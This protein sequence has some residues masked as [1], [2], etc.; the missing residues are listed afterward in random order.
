[1]CIEDVNVQSLN[2]N[3]TYDQHSL[4]DN[5]EYFGQIKY[6]EEKINDIKKENKYYENK[7]ILS[8]YFEK[9][10]LYEFLR[11]IV[12]IGTL[13][14]KG[15]K[16]DK[17]AN[18]IV[19]SNIDKFYEKE[20]RFVMKSFLLF[21][22]LDN[23]DFFKDSEFSVMVPATYVGKRRINQNIRNLWSITFDLDDVSPD[24][25]VNLI[26]MIE[27]ELIPKPTI[28][29]NSGNGLHLYYVLTYPIKYNEEN[30]IQLTKF[31]YAL[32]DLI[33]SKH[34]SSNHVTQYQSVTQA[35]RL[36][37]SSSKLGKNFPVE[38]YI[39]GDTVSLQYLNEFLIEQASILEMLNEGDSK[40][41][42]ELSF[43]NYKKS[44]YK[45]KGRLN[46]Y[47]NKVRRIMTKYNISDLEDKHYFNKYN[48]NNN[49]YIKCENQ[50]NILDRKPVKRKTYK[51]NSKLYYWWLRRIREEAKIGTRYNCVSMLAVY[52]AKC[53]IDYNELVKDAMSLLK[54][55]NGIEGSTENPF[56]IKDINSALLMF[57]EKFKT[58]TIDTIELKCQISI[59]RN[60]R[61]GK[62]RKEHLEENRR[63]LLEKYSLNNRKWW[64]NNGRK[65]MSIKVIDYIKTHPG[66][67]PTQYAKDLNISRVTVYKYLKI[68]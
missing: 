67:T 47:E 64:E 68:I 10:S 4:I 49:N 43:S 53:G 35:Y 38:A 21:D 37:G 54:D 23:V 19:V 3:Q 16:E 22:E 32:T 36:P 15:K 8:T 66:K 58:I 60:K 46:L 63:I 56:K 61:N 7:K 17:K 5:D 65:S 1:M 25:L 48:N 34:T 42:V 28:I 44:H 27:T 2:T 6:S 24:H 57:N 52:A 11:K 39:V 51:T 9:L 13:S 18:L 55:F 50:Q 30:R 29:S 14:R 12:P 31:K 62:K 40:N 26:W 45:T 20:N 33:W 41:E 59:N